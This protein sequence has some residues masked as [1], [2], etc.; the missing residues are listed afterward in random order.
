MSN[1]VPGIIF[2]IIF[3][4]GL[5]AVLFW[6]KQKEVPNRFFFSVIWAL[7]SLFIY[8]TIIEIHKGSCFILIPLGFFALCLGMYFS[9]K[10]RLINGFLFN[11]FVL[12]FGAYLVYNAYLTQDIIVIGLL[13][14][15]LLLFILTGIFGLATLVIF[16]YLNAAVVLKKERRSLP[17][18][19]TLLLAI[20]LTF[21]LIYDYFIA[22]N[23]PIWLTSLLS[24]V[25][26]ILVYFIITFLNFLTVSI[27]YQFNHPRYQQDY[28][29]TLGAGLIE[30]KRVT[31]LLARRI[32]TAISFYRRQKKYGKKTAKLVMSGGQG[33]D[34]AV[35]EAF[36]MK[37]YALSQGIPEEDILL[38]DQSTNTL[39]NMRFSKALMEKLT[40]NGFKAIFTSNNYHIFRAGIYARQAHLKADGLGAKTALYYLP[41][42][43]LREYIAILMMHKKRHIVVVAL[44][45]GITIMATLL[46]LISKFLAN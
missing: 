22:Q 38:E 24:G 36:A 33:A 41:N 1:I 45:M 16:L 11:C 42:A 4:I 12:I 14:L 20:F 30:G 8:L 34:E 32:D 29:I 13:G 43:F 40:P 35:S 25:P 44:I 37:E 3:F 26:L 23:L 6:R 21:V 31:P 7:A 2:I 39:E 5:V 15:A 9:G 19:L 27:L 28:I 18:L 46:I 10:A 17:N